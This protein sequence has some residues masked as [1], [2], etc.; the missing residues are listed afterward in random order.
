MRAGL[1]RPKRHHGFRWSSLSRQRY[2]DSDA[3]RD[4]PPEMVTSVT[5]QAN[6]GDHQ[7]EC[8]LEYTKSSSSDF[9]RHS[10]LSILV[11]FII[12]GLESTH[13]I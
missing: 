11:S 10:A 5:G 6:L 2:E 4:D 13:L 7:A 3:R 8:T 9:H 12:A 1:V